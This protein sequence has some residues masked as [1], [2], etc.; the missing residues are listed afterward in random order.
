MTVRLRPLVALGLAGGT[1]LALS[2]SAAPAGLVL[3][4]AAGDANALNGQGVVGGAPSTATSPVS[5]DG[6]DFTKVTL[7]NTLTGKGKKVTC[8]GFTITMEFNGPVDTSDPAIYRL[9]GTTTANDGIFQLYLNDGPA[10]GGTEVRFGAGAEDNTVALAHPAKVD[11]NKVVLTITTA[12][13]KGF[14]DKPKDMIKDIQ[15]DTRVSSGVSFVPQVD[16]IDATDKTFTMC[17]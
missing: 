3:T 6:L 4:D 7:A 5:Y 9:R 15:M 14:G 10:G 2:A 8:S 12:D 1:A 13:M 17:G 16:E 11:G